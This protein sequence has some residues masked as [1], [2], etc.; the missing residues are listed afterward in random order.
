MH[1]SSVTTGMAERRVSAQTRARTI[2][3]EIAEAGTPTEEECKKR[4]LA[5]QN[6]YLSWVMIWLIAKKL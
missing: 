6:P 5:E 4:A 1:P 3:A 2:A